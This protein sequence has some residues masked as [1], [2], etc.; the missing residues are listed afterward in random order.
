MIDITSE[1]V[2]SLNDASKYLP[3]RRAG[4]KPHTSTLFRWAQRGVRG[5]RLETIQVGG[6]LCTSLEALQR[7]FNTLTRPEHGNRISAGTTRARETA[8]HRAEQELEK[9]GI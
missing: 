1:R 5:V 4:K 6:T 8:L 3:R 2:V 9:A 7:F